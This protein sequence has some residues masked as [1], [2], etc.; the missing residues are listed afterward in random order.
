M[1]NQGCLL[2]V[3]QVCDWIMTGKSEKLRALKLY[4]QTHMASGFESSARGSIPYFSGFVYR[5]THASFQS[6]LGTGADGGIS[7]QEHWAIWLAIFC[8][9]I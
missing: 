1:G 9:R 7:V 8:I 2:G 6:V 3:R 4:R 5:S